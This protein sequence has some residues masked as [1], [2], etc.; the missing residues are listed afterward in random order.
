M[1]HDRHLSDHDIEQLLMGND[2]DPSLDG[3][4]TWAAAIRRASDTSI[5][6]SAVTAHV[7]A[8]AAAAAAAVRLPT[9]PAPGT[10]ETPLMLRRIYNSF[11]ARVAAISAVFVVATGGIAAA[12]VLPDS[13][14]EP[15]ADVYGIVGFDFHPEEASDNDGAGG[16]DGDIGDDG[17]IVP[18]GVKDDDDDDQGEDDDS[19][20]DH[21]HH[22]DDD[23]DQGQDKDQGQDDDDHGQDKDQGQDDDDHGQDKDQGQ[24]DDDH[25][26]DKDQDEGKT[27]DDD[28]D[29]GD[30]DDNDD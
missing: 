6:S 5:S 10:P 3:V 30:N 27:T 15:I 21:H 22:D 20:D 11:A 28:D 2:V 25:G 16:D 14:Q 7:T 17:A 23:D 24:D 19:Q 12:G 18:V 26:Q 4:A 1:S 8:A 29:D 13:V 9:H